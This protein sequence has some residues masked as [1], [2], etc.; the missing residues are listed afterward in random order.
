MADLFDYMLW[1]GD[2]PFGRDGL[3][4][5]DN[6]ILCRAAYLPFDGVVPGSMEKKITLGQA[7]RALLAQLELEGRLCMEMDLRLCRALAECPRFAELPVLG[8]EN[9]VDPAR[10]LQFSA[11]VFALTPDTYFIAFR[12]TD[13]TIVGW[14][15]DFNMSFCTPVPAQLEAVRYLERCAAALPGALIPGGHSKGGNLA[16]YASAFAP[17]EV[18]KR[19]S[20]VYSNDGP[21]FAQ[22]VLETDGYLAVCERIRSYVPQSS[23]VGMLLAHEEDY[24]IVKSNQV[25]IWQHDLYSWELMGRSLTALDKVTNSSLFIDRTLKEWLAGLTAE[26]REKFVDGVFYLLSQTNASTFN[27]LNASRMANI[28]LVIK[29]AAGLDEETRG[30]I[31]YALGRLIQATRGNLGAFLPRFAAKKDEN[32]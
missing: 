8:Y 7:V 5:V 3:N 23:V 19:I 9:C 17:P 2:L 15:E 21:G 29:S 4:E 27:E 24:T 14:K 31:L 13:N 28:A 11:V 6:L 20:A 32:P 25:S 30:H 10:E 1:R 22:A 18:Q 26:Q 12:G 16:V